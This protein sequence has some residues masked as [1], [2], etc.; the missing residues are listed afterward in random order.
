M[1]SEIGT[2]QKQ[3]YAQIFDKRKE[4]VKP[5]NVPE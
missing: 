4:Y 2:L 5:K 1:F 3:L